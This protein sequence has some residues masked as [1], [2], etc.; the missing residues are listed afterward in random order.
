M[1]SISS[2]LLASKIRLFTSPASVLVCLVFSLSPS[3]KTLDIARCS[4][5]KT[6]ASPDRT[7]VRNRSGA[8]Q[9]AD[10]L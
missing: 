10:G 7:E 3:Q 6:A 8:S 9:K 4:R 2:Y 1:Y 5:T